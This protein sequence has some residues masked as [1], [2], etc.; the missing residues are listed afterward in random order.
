[1]LKL[2]SQYGK[3]YLREAVPEPTRQSTGGQYYGNYEAGKKEEK[4]R[5]RLAPEDD[6]SPRGGYD[7]KSKYDAGKNTDYL[8]DEGRRAR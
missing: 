6:V 7:F 4:P 5:G 3:S 1:M 8:Q 2:N